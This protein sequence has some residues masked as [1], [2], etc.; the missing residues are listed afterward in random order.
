LARNAV[1]DFLTDA[2]FWLVD[3]APIEAFSAPLFI[4]IAGFH[5]ISMPELQLETQSISPANNLFGKQSIKK[6]SVSSIT[7]QRGAR[8]FDSDFWN[9]TMAAL[10]GDTATQTMNF[11]SGVGA[12]GLGSVGGPTPRRD[13][14]LV[15]FF[16]NFPIPL[17]PVPTDEGRIAASVAAGAAQVGLAGAFG[18]ARTALFAAGAFVEGVPKLPARAWL[19]SGC[20]PTRYKPGSDFDATSGQVSMMEL[21]VAPERMEEI[22]L[23]A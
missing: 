18:G 19:L 13:L 20:L 10:T 17:G 2:N 11:R 6:G 22:S 12:Q 14:L 8:F 23:A 7:L 21:E 4:P 9:W 1:T 3:V 5:S 15:H 16:R